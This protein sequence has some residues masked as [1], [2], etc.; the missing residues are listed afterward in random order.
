MVVDKFGRQQGS[1]RSGGGSAIVRGPPGIGFKLTT[2]NDFDIENR[3]ICNVGDPK[4]DG[5]VV[6]KKCTLIVREK[7]VSARKRRLI[8]VDEPELDTDATTKKYV[9]KKARKAN[10][11]IDEL[12]NAFTEEYIPQLINTQKALMGTFTLIMNIT[13]NLNSIGKQWTNPMSTL[14]LSQLMIPL[15]KNPPTAAS[16]VALI[17]KE[18]EQ[19]QQDTQFSPPSSPSEHQPAVENEQAAAAAGSQE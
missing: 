1:G 12:I 3:R 2:N 18:T 4:D 13:D 7:V 14:P 8:D 11:R 5:D 16:L 9:K 6:N 17:I 15:L 10:A 19:P